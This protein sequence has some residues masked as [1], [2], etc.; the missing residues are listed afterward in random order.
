MLKLN[1]ILSE[2]EIKNLK[3]EIEDC[4]YDIDTVYELM[5]EYGLEPDYLVELI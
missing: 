3:Q 4:A 5:S 1:E 2:E